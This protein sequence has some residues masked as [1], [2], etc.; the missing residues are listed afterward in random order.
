LSPVLALTGADCGDDEGDDAGTAT[1]ERAAKA[2]VVTGSGDI[3]GVVEQFRRLLGPDNGGAPKGDPAGRRE[4]TWDKVPDRQAAPRFLPS[5]FFNA[6]EAPGAR[7]AVLETPGAG[8]MVSADDDNPSGAEP[9]FGHINRSYSGQFKVFSLERLFSPVGSNLVDLRFRVPGTETPG[10]V[11]G[12]GAVYTDVDRKE[13]TAFEYFDSAG[14]SLG[15]YAVPV[16][17]GG[18]SFL[19]AVFER[20]VVARVRIEYGSGKLG[21]DESADYDV[22]VMDDFIYG[23]PQAERK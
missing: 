1:E 14:K 23:E 3:T 17:V 8:V 6:R 19:G 13:N 2:R 20:P 10:V 11:K 15:Q 18:L 5:D 22:A 4:L 16:S 12:F 7:G 21:P 9:R